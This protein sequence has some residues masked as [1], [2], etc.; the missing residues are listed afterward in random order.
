MKKTPL[1]LMMATLFLM[2]TGCIKSLDLSTLIPDPPVIP[3]QATQTTVG[4]PTGAIV[5]KTIGKSG[6]S[7]LSADGNAELIFPANALSE[8]VDISVQAISNLAPN[9]SGDAYRFLPEGTKF[10]QPVML[11]FH[12]TDDDLASTLADLMGIAFQDSSGGWYRLNN[13][14]NDTVN[15]IVYAPIRHFTDYTHFDV[16]R[17]RPPVKTVQI[18]KS[19]SLEV[20]VVETSDDELTQLNGEEVAPLIKAASKT[21]IWS[22]NGIVNGNGAV[23]TTTGS[24]AS[25]IFTAPGKVPKQNPVAVSAQIDIQFTCEGKTFNKTS[26]VSYIKVIAGAKFRL[27]FA[28]TEDEILLKYS[29]ETNMIVLVNPDGTVIISDIN[30]FAPSSNPLSYKD[31]GC[32][33]S[34]VEDQIGESNIIS[35]TGTTKGTDPILTLNFTHSGTVFPTFRT[36]CEDGSSETKAGFPIF[37]YPSTLT[38]TLDANSPSYEINDGHIKATL[39]RTND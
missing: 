30:N 25:T 37:G 7:I 1:L 24:S 3:S 17:I 29:D 21:I 28:L 15:K 10:L 31:G 5:T 12:Y 16:L 23:G 34:W 8:N 18:N 33:F 39:T 35:A 32:T 27:E 13:F 4:D 2:L 38:F 26:L 11:K 19:Q 20:T 36:D 9:G 6:G 14:K 22:V